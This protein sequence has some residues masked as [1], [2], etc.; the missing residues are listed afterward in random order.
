MQART[1]VNR[2]LVSQAQ[3]RGSASRTVASSA[4]QA[5]Q[6]VF[7]QPPNPS[8]EGTANGG[9]RLR[10]SPPPVAPLSAPH[11]KR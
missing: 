8:I 9:A 11:V 5:I 3:L 2:K 7:P 4:R 1:K 10:A 6:L